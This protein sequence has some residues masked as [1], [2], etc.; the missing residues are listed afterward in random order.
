MLHLTLM[1]G[2]EVRLKEQDNIV[3]TVMG[4]TEILMPTLA[5]KMV[6]LRR[7]KREYGSE[8]ESAS[9]RTNV[10]TLMGA[11]VGMIPTMGRE[12]EELIQLRESGM[13][14]NEE[15]VQL[16]HEVLEK[17]DLDVIEYVTIMGGAGEERP[18]K[19][20]ETAAL[21]RLVLRGILSGDEAEEVKQMLM[22]KDF[23]GMKSGPVQEKLRT[24]LFPS[25]LYSVSSKRSALPSNLT[26]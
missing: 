22:S 3:V 6:Y 21:D 15:L 7:M 24:L 26:E 23:S 13:M 12:I 8:L 16:W 1:G 20:A 10:I 19:K 9:R 17:G 4:G 11:T 5:E 25:G 2:S 18:G 14:S